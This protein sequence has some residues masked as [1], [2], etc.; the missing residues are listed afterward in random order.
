MILSSKP[1]VIL[2]NKYLIVCFLTL[3]S[4]RSV[5]VFA[6]KIDRK[7][8]VSRHNVIVKS[9]D[10]LASLTVGNGKFAFTV[11]A[12]GLQSFPEYYAKGVPLGTQSEWG[13]HTFPNPEELKFSETLKSYNFNGHAN[14]LYSVQINEP[15]KNKKAVSYFRENP[16]RLQLGNVGFEIIKKDGSVAQPKDIQNI[17]Q[18]LNLWTGEISSNFSVD[19][20]VVKVVTYADADKDVIAVKVT[21]ELLLQKRLKIRFRFP[22]PTNEFKDVGTNYK[23]P[24]A[25]QTVLIQT[26]KSSALF[27]RKLDDDQYYVAA[28]W[29]N[30]ATI[31]KN[32]EHD[33]ILLPVENE[34]FEMSVAF[35]PEKF[36]KPEL[37]FSEIQ[38][39]SGSV[40]SKFWLSGA[41]IDLAGSTD[42]RA[43]ELER[44]II[45][46]Q[47]LTRVQCAGNF[48]PQETGLTYNSWFGKP[49]ME[50]YWW[51]AAH[52]ALWG[53]T[54][55]LEKGMQ[56]YFSAYNGAADIAKRQGYKG[57]RWQKMTDHA[58]VE[59]PSSVGSFLIW[60]QPHAIYLAEL[61]Y[62]NNPSK[63]VLEKYEKL[64]FGSAE[65]MASFAHYD[66]ATKHYNLGKGIIPAQECYNPLETF[67]SP[68]EL[69]YWKW[70]LQVAQKWKV[71]SGQQPDK[72]WQKVIDEIA[73]MAQKDGLYKAAESVEDSYSPNSKFTIDHPAVLAALSTLP[74]NG[75]VDTAVMQ[76][77][78][79]TIEKVWHWERTWGWDFPMIAMTATRLHQPDDAMDALFKNITTNTYLPNGHNYQ[80]KRLTIY[81]PGN[82]GLLSAVALMCAGF[83]D[84]KIP[85]PGFPKNGKWK[86]KWEGLKPQ[87]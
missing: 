57:V 82:G 67:N 56:W 62:R 42:S 65:F 10:T 83:D 34:S 7:A 58:G 85:N 63:A 39:N 53:R 68:Y 12:T 14:S 15:E 87:P 22:Y 9:A 31:S 77:T 76:K 79:N 35:S 17:N 74:A 81:L 11:D 78:Y 47:Y 71:R 41:A 36:L 50:M 1:I 86:V 5:N 52:Y 40:W 29:S 55:L 72:E 26:D 54:D 46:S 45:L 51:H 8:V 32:A 28:K 24:E 66:P 48:P 64:V 27:S 4:C 80:D 13:W 75:F 18:Q 19:G 37:S 25:H 30:Q 49:H 33:F 73:P 59:A 43:K 70:A 16:A 23:H 61:I 84:N 60:Q 21:S 69:A 44:R 3:L 2:M 38:K 6:Q 20:T